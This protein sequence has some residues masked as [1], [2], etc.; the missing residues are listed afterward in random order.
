MNPNWQ[1]TIMARRK[2]PA[3]YAFD[4]CDAYWAQTNCRY[5]FVLGCVYAHMRSEYATVWFAPCLPDDRQLVRIPRPSWTVNLPR[6]GYFC[7]PYIHL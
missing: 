5:R 7:H 2:P 3:R 6:Y 4:D 1:I